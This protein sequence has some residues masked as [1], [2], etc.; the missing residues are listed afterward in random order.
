MVRDD[1]WLAAL[2]G[3]PGEADDDF[4]ADLRDVPGLLI[5]LFSR[6]GIAARLLRDRLL[7]ETDPVAIRAWLLQAEDNGLVKRTRQQM[8]GAQ[9]PEDQ[10]SITQAGLDYLAGRGIT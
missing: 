4:I 10:W 8:L 6:P 2:K 3:N 1:L 9:A 7:G 5:D